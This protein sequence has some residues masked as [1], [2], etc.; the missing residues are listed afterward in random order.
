MTFLD[1]C[2]GCMLGL[3]VGDAL[4]YP[5]E[6]H[7]APH[8]SDMSS[9]LYSDDTQMSIATAEG[10]LQDGS[11]LAVHRA[12]LRWL[13]TQSRP[14][15]ARAPGNT[16]LS[17]LASGM[18][19]TMDL[20]INTSKGC[21]GVMRVAPAGLVFTPGAAFRKGADYAAITHGHPSGYLSAGFLSELISCLVEGPGLREGL[22][23]ATGRLRAHAGHEETLAA[24]TEA[25]RLAAD[26]DRARSDIESLGGGW[27]GEQALAIAVYCA[28]R[29]HDDFQ[30]G[31]LASVNHAGDSDSTGC[32]CGAILGTLLGISGIPPRWIERVEGSRS[33]VK[34][35][36]RLAGMERTGAVK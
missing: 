16:C 6:F 14:G 23:A 33:L 26:P 28:L 27:V 32:I 3:A 5:V 1:R 24:V 17:A 15:Q 13:Q 35:A 18:I 29:F 2:L 11:T 10:I 4:G 20:P 8:V 12:Y 22:D 25:R 7:R 30:S 36:E 21:G 31:V 9:P 19:G 34:L